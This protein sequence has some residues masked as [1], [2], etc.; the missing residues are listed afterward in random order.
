M[1]LKKAQT[2]MLDMITYHNLTDWGFRFDKAVNRL[3]LCSHKR[4]QLFLS[5]HATSVNSEEVVLNTILHEIAHAL[6]DSNHGHDDVWRNKAISIGCDGERCS[7]IAVKAPPKYTIAC[8]S[9]DQIRGYLYRLT[10]KYATRLDM[11]WCTQC[12]KE[13]SRGKLVLTAA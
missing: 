13:K 1:D 8:K 12:G 3:G 6:V 5:I 7:E 11:M 10:N 4:Q 2:M 9:C